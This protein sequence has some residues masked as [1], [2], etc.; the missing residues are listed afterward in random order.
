MGKRAV[1]Y[2]V[3]TGRLFRVYRG[4]YAV[5]RPPVHPIERAAAAVLACGPRAALSHG[6][7]M[8]LWGYWRR[9]DEPVDVTVAGDRRAKGIRIHRCSTLLRRDVI[10]HQ[11]IRVTSRARTLLDVAPQI[12]PK[13]LTRFI[14]DSRRANHLTLTALADVAVR[15][16]SH[17]GARALMKEAQNPHNPTRSEGEDSF[18]AWCERYGLPTPVMDTNLHGFEV[19]AYFAQEKLVV[20]LDGWPF[21]RDRNKFESDRDQDA[22]LLAHQI[23]TVRI[24]YDRLDNDAD[25]EAARLDSIL[26]A[27]RAA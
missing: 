22:T 8:T 26:E 14:N 9:W 11:G 23:A 10:V 18:P 25:R 1:Y 16:R 2:A 6:S 17:P 24:T 15:N 27:R 21:H 7:A 3:R 4:V 5:G 19:D 20:E 12:K 13:S